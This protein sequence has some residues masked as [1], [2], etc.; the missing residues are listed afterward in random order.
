[1]NGLFITGSDTDVGKTYVSCLIAQGLLQRSFNVIPR[2]PVESGCPRELDELLPQ[3][4]RKLS[5]AAHYTGS[6]H[7][8]CPHRF[9]PAIS[10]ALAASLNNQA[11][12]LKD[13]IDCCQVDFSQEN[14]FLITEGAGGFLSPICN[15]GL[16]A[17]LAS[18]LKLPLIL[19]I[20][21][22]VGCINQA[23]LT[24]EAISQRKLS[25]AAII[26]N[27]IKTA[28][29]S[30]NPEQNKLSQQVL[31]DNIQQITQHT[32][33]PVFTLD[34][35]QSHLPEELFTSLLPH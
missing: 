22:R 26:L 3:D 10:P 28:D 31:N 32:Q 13:L 4:A 27:Q 5:Q 12:Y 19:V 1:M 7:E 25:I 9:V 6:L 8:V 21:N 18:A 29:N 35:N 2:K 16:N 33:C 24:F 23:L 30:N 17:D 20:E 34:K 14:N 15:D 11:V